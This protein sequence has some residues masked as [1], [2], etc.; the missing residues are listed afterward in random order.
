MIATLEIGIAVDDEPFL[1]AQ[2]SSYA[3][4]NQGLA[5]EHNEGYW[6]PPFVAYPVPFTF[7]PPST[8]GSLTDHCSRAVSEDGI[9]R[10]MEQ[11]A[12]R[13]GLRDVSLVE[14]EGF[15]EIKVSPRSPE[16]VKAFSIRRFGLTR[17]SDDCI[18]N[19]ADRDA[20][21]G[22]LYIPFVNGSAA[23]GIRRFSALHQRDEM[24]VAGK[25]IQSNLEHVLCDETMSSQILADAIPMGAAD[26]LS[27]DRGL[28]VACDLSRYGSA[29]TLARSTMSG[30]LGSGEDAAETFARKVSSLLQDFIRSLG[31]IQVQLAGDGVIAALPDRI[32]DAVPERFTRVVESWTRL[33]EGLETL[34]ARTSSSKF[35][36][37]S[38]MSI[39]YG[40]YQF[41][42]I[43]GP[44]SVV[45]GFNGRAVVEAARLEG[46]MSE[47]F[48]VRSAEA[49]KHQGVI[50]D[51][52]AGR[53][54]ESALEQLRRSEVS[55]ASLSAKEFS[56]EAT[57]YD[58]GRH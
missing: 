21:F 34:N 6:A 28:V 9:A 31:T 10:D 44:R 11:L 54:D 1:V 5:A 19:L 30:Y 24:W 42:R 41:G 12:Y 43:S 16:L 57:L 39:H 26:F 13:L 15:V 4:R 7:A 49:P 37:G 32:G 52:V 29:L 47:F 35:E 25:P 48:R 45:V 55:R 50:S 27:N 3:L 33:I 58:L 2:L 46:A 23:S 53:L 56:A 20:L 8:L 18:P 36:V 22:F 14:R 17:L 51:E 38:R 40:E